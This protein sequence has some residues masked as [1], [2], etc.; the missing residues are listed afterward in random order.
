MK[1]KRNQPRPQPIV[2]VVR[3][4]GPA[5][6]ALLHSKRTSDFVVCLI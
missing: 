6:V 1:F 5:L 4:A 3:L 2:R